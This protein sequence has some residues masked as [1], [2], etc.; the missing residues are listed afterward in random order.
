MALADVCKITRAPYMRRSMYDLYDDQQG[1]KAGTSN[2]EDP[3][4]L[5]PPPPDTHPITSLGLIDAQAKGTGIQIDYDHGTTTVG[6]Q[7]QGG[8]ILAAD[9]RSTT[10]SYISSQTAKKVMEISDRMVATTAGRA[11]D[12]MYWL[13]VLRRE[14]RLHELRYKQ[15][16]SV[17]AA[18][19]IMFNICY[20]HRKRGLDMGVILAGHGGLKDELEL[21]YVDSDGYRE[22]GKLFSVGSGSEFA[23]GILNTKYDWEMKDEAVHELVQ[24][25]IY[26][27]ALQDA[28]SGGS[29][30][31]Y[32]VTRSGWKKLSETDFA[33]L[34]E[35]YQG[36]L[37]GEATDSD[38]SPPASP[39]L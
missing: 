9:T 32:H 20:R 33:E 11:A 14:C 27:S 5:A 28:F 12:C 15:T 19:K 30:M 1:L 23:Y 22:K 39:P 6:V 13:R 37:K 26:Y 25:A 17:T 8:I 38:P 2:F 4:N 18:S 34:H 7:Y 24:R 10:G 31:V 36:Q 29:V 21:Y 3:Y 16:L 35:K